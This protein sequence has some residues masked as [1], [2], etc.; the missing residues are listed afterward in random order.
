MPAEEPRQRPKRL[1]SLVQASVL[2]AKLRPLFDQSW[3]T[4]TLRQ[5]VYLIYLLHYVRDMF[6]YAKTISR[7]LQVNHRAA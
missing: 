3:Q 5:A 2:K 1:R 6:L 7:T 4:P